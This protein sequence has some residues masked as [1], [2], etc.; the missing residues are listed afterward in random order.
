MENNYSKAQLTWLLV[1]R[2]FVGWHF[3]FEGMVKVLNP[4][5]TA[6]AY[7]VDSQGPFRSFFVNMAGNAGLMNTVNFLNEWAL[8]LIGLGL[9]IGAFSRLSCIGGILLLIMY[10]LSHPALIGAKYAMPF[11]GSYFL[12]DKNLVELAALGVLFVFPT[13]RVIGFDRL[14][15]KV[16]PSGFKKFI[17]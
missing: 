11:E 16:L 9:I 12:I 8:V 10:T 13:A 14:L 3:L 1:L 15:V 7:L 4:N 6:A 2:I 5:W 17:I